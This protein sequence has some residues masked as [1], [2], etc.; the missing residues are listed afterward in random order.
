VLM[1][2]LRPGTKPPK[3]Q[4]K[5]DKGAGIAGALAAPPS[6]KPRFQ[7]HDEPPDP[8]LR[9]AGFVGG[10]Q[11]FNDHVQAIADAHQK[12][13]GFLPS[14]GLTLDIARSPLS[15]HE[16]PQLFPAVNKR[17][18]TLDRML[19]TAPGYRDPADVLLKEF[20]QA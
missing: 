13:F 8:V 7:G 14:A 20:A 2:D 1:R 6:P 5:S 12:T 4:T 19:A 9:M 15:L 10:I 11:A 16:Y 3:P 17:T 18:Y